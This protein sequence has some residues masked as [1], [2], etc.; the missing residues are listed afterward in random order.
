MDAAGFG[1]AALFGMSEGGPQVIV[2]A[3]KRPERTRALILTGTIPNWGLAGWDDMD[4]DPAELRARVLAELGE[5]YTPSTEQIARV[6]GIG[7]AVRS[8]W[9][10]VPQPAS[11]CRQCPVDYASS[12]C[13]SG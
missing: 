12:P 7:R 3:A 2:F 4:R 9:G 5:D 6:Q 13:L 10:A 1:Q 11:A 8:G